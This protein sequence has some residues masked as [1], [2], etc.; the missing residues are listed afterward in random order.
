MLMRFEIHDPGRRLI[1]LDAGQAWPFSASEWTGFARRDTDDAAVYTLDVPRYRRKDLS[2][3]V[4]GQRVIVR[5]E[6]S[7]GLLKPKLRRSFVRSFTL[8]DM[9]DPSDVRADFH[10]GVLS[11]SVAKRPAARRIA[12]QVE[13][14]QVTPAATSSAGELQ[15]RRSFWQRLVGKLRAA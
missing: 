15:P 4:D 12:V 1:E 9:L 2:V 10:E 6:Q 11:L 3:E 13:G 14:K 8:P 5:G 7:E